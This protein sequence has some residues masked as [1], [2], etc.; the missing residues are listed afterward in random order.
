MLTKFFLSIKDKELA[1][2]YTLS[3]TEKVFKTGVVL[4]LIRI[5]LVIWA[6][7]GIFNNHYVSHEYRINF[8]AT[9]SAILL[10]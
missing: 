10:A 8:V 1:R 9:H 2:K 7:V 6:F 5:A 4:T 3:H